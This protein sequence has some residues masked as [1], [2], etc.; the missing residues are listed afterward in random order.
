MVLTSFLTETLEPGS[1]TLGFDME[2]LQL[3][4]GQIVVGAYV[5]ARFLAGQSYEKF[6]LVETF[7][8]QHG[9]RACA[10]WADTERNALRAQTK[11]A[12]VHI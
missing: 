5:W 1:T 11:D 3:M 4:G 12:F 10:I 7:C 2:D 6:Q 8:D 9:F